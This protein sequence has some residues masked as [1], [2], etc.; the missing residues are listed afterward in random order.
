ML[1]NTNFGKFGL[2]VVLLNLVGCAGYHSVHRPTIEE[3]T[4]FKP[5]CEIAEQQ[6]IYL[7]SLKPTQDEMN[8]ANSQV[9][10]FGKLSKEYTANR[11]VG[12]GRYTYIINENIRDLYKQCTK[13][14]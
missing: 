8:W 10:I 11:D 9:Q 3:L 5:N 4:R 14:F 13:R 2:C 12:N 7:K 1:S 6:L